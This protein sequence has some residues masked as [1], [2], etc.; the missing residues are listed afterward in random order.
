MEKS[1]YKI[2]SQLAER[3]SISDY[4]CVSPLLFSLRHKIGISADKC[5]MFFIECSSTKPALDV[6]LELISLKFN[7]KCQLLEYDQQDAKPFENT[8]TIIQLKADIIEFQQ[9]FVEVVA[10]ALRTLPERP[11]H[12]QLKLSLIHI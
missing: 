8:Y 7:C 5:P 2:F 12:S 3:Q 9:Y 1:A 10:L 6:N 11:T 4:F